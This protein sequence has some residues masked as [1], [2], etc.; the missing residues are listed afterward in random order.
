MEGLRTKARNIILLFIPVLLLGAEGHGDLISSLLLALVIL[1]PS[2]KLAGLAAER[3]RQP[4]VMGEL[5]AGMLLGNLG[6][7]GLHGLDYLKS[8]P[9]VEILASLE[10]GRASCRER[11]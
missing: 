10:I 2:A 11:V 7:V 6:L 4:A 5:I 3:L 8:D 9:A 1:L